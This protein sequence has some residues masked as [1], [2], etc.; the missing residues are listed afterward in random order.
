MYLAPDD[1]KRMY[2]ILKGTSL[3]IR[4]WILCI[5]NLCMLLMHVFYEPQIQYADV[6]LV[7]CLFLQLMVHIN[8]R[9]K[10]LLALVK[11]DD[12]PLDNIKTQAEI[13]P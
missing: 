5:C 4:E 3:S 2:Q 13:K 8:S 9:F 7:I 11:H 6:G 10:A 12:L 1:K